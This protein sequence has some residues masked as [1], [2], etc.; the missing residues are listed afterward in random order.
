[1]ANPHPHSLHRRLLPGLRYRP[2]AFSA[3]PQLRST[4]TRDRGVVKRVNQALRAVGSK[5]AACFPLK[6]KPRVRSGRPPRRGSAQPPSAGGTPVHPSVSKKR[7]ARERNGSLRHP[8]REFAADM[9]AMRDNGKGTWGGGVACGAV[10]RVRPPTRANG[11]VGTATGGRRRIAHE[12]HPAAHQVGH[13]CVSAVV[14]R[15]EADGLSGLASG[16][17]VP[18]SIRPRSTAVS[19]EQKRACGRERGRRVAGR[20]DGAVNHEYH[21]TVSLRC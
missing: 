7:G 21:L 8:T 2:P 1:V 13:L 19:S 12:L 11:P 20:S 15:D 9:E 14:L 16:V 5:A 10:V 18:A 17:D 4:A 3:M 6:P